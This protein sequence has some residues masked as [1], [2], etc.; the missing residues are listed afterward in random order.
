MKDYSRGIITKALNKQFAPEFLNRLDEIINFDQ[1]EMDSLIKIVD[2]ELEG[3]YKRVETIG[4]KL[5]MDDEARKFI[6]NKGYDI[7]YGARPLKRAIQTHVEDALAEVIL[8]S[9]IQEGDTIRGTY[10]KEKDAIVMT[11]EK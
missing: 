3:L 8:G 4:Y 5:V 10:D 9:E 2:I 6:A 1:L 11:V 7:Q